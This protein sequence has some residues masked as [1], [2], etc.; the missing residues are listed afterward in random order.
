MNI[1][2]R[3]KIYFTISIILVLASLAAFLT[4]GLKLSIDFTGGSLLQI[5]VGEN[6]QTSANDIQT[7]LT[8]GDA[9]VLESVIVQPTGEQGFILRFKSVNEEEHQ[10]I[11]AKLRSSLAPQEDTQASTT[12]GK[13]SQ[14]KETPAVTGVKAVNSKGEPVDIKVDA[15]PASESGSNETVV[16]DSFES[17]GPTIGNELKQR[18]VY[19]VL[20]V[21]AAIIIYIAWAFRKVSQPVASWK[22]GLAAVIALTHD[23][24]IPIGIFAV[25]G[26]FLGVEVD[27]LFVTA[28]L[29]ILG[30]SVHDTIVVFDRIRENL[31][32]SRH[33]GTFEE[34]V[35]ISVNETVRR[36]I[37]TSLTALLALLA[38]FLFGGESIKYFVLALML[39]IIFGTYSSIFI[40]SP[41]LV[42]WD[43]WSRKI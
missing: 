18:S 19:A 16:E 22:Y 37:N 3:R 11:L 32:H 43:K 41:L 35:N 33:R 34:I 15:S 36:S 27:I 9:K 40:A 30:F 25:L 38:I 5:K 31:A 21:L 24:L 39:G 26:K 23:V 6:V 42:V 7:L 2:Q 20:A 14:R 28:L 1:I 4:F 13:A 12:P 29:T 8:S 17:I 10:A